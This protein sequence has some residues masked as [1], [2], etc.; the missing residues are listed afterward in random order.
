[1]REKTQTSS[2]HL[3]FFFFRHLL[4]TCSLS[5]FAARITPSLPSRVYCFHFPVDVRCREKTNDFP[6]HQL[7]FISRKNTIADS[8]N[9]CKRF[10]NVS[11]LSRTFVSDRIRPSKDAHGY[12]FISKRMNKC[13]LGCPP[14]S[15]RLG[16]NDQIETKIKS[17]FQGVF[18]NSAQKR[19]FLSHVRR[20]SGRVYWT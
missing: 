15:Y 11:K 3:S 2:F 17:K 14:L 4:L 7:E 5:T 1:M 12:F 8:L 9:L 19:G 20:V 13:E 10:R 18:G 16:I 6:S